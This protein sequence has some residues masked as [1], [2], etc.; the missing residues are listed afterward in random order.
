MSLAEMPPD[1]ERPKLL[2]IGS[3]MID[4]KLKSYI[5]AL[6]EQ[7]K[8]QIEV[9]EIDSETEEGQGKMEEYEIEN[10]D[11]LPATLIIEDDESIY[12]AW[13]G[14]DLPQID[15]VIFEVGQLTGN[16]EV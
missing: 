10:E 1:A 7:L 15:Q 13:Y 3:Y 11:S 4:D 16:G 8:D 14:A 9:T 6:R 12:K 5:D 2:V